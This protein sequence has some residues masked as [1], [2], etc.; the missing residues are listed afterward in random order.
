MVT[1]IEKQTCD[2]CGSCC[3][4]GGPALHTQ[5]L[6]LLEAGSLRRGHLITVR[7]GELAY[8][9]MEESATPVAE[10]FLKLQGGSGSWCCMFYDDAAKVCTIYNHR[11]IACG[12][13]DCTSPEALLAITGKDLLTRFDCMSDDDPLLQIVRHNE[14]ECPCPDMALLSKELRSATGKSLLLDELT[15]LVNT[16]LAF[17]QQA[18]GT[19]DLSVA[20]EL[21]YFGRPLFQQLLPLGVRIHESLAGLQ[22]Y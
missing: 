12:L 13:L 21:F 7:K 20:E 15:L 11:P 16:D 19:Q 3:K 4:Q 5:D 1:R 9:P 2:R 17:R 14:Q 22:L 6:A 10:E 8:Q 18:A